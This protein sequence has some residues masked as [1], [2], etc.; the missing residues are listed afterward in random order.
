[1]YTSAYSFRNHTFSLRLEGQYVCTLLKCQGTQLVSGSTHPPN[2][3]AVSF[4][5]TR[6]K[7]KRKKRS[8][9]TSTERDVRAKVAEQR[10]G[11]AGRRGRSTGGIQ[12][13]AFAGRY[14]VRPRSTPAPQ[15]F[16]PSILQQR[17]GSAGCKGRSVGREPE[18]ALPGRISSQAA[19]PQASRPFSP[20][21]VRLPTANDATSGSITVSVCV[22][23]TQSRVVTSVNPNP[24]ATFANQDQEP[25]SSCSRS[26]SYP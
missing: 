19:P 14:M 23:A 4:H 6:C 3:T 7:R 1:M 21:A 20:S 5:R 2:A 8:P 17:G 15:T 12:G 11:K 25:R 16:P 24:P 9:D 22:S 13:P 10:G 18:S 26:D